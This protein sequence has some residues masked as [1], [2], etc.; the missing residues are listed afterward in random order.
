[1]L[2]LA[3]SFGLIAGRSSPRFLQFAAG[4]D[5]RRVHRRPLLIPFSVGVLKASA[6]ERIPDVRTTLILP[7][8]ARNRNREGTLDRIPQAQPRPHLR[9]R[10]TRINIPDA[11]H[12]PFT[13]PLLMPLARQEFVP[14][15][16]ELFA[17][18]FA[19]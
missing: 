14:Q 15:S 19:I 7:M 13:R 8:S 1:L 3:R 5:S 16:S 10:W 2:R 17:K 6:T 11:N 18:L 12:D 9:H 4:R